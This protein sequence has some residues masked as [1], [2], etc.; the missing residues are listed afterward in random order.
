[1]VNYAR[2]ENCIIW[3]EDLIEILSASTSFI[4]GAKI[5][6][7]FKDYI[8]RGEIVILG[9]ADPA[10]FEKYMTKYSGF[11]SLFRQIRIEDVDDEKAYFIANSV[12]KKLEL[13]KKVQI[14][15]DVIDLIIEL[16]NRFE[17]YWENPGKSINL[18]KQVVRSKFTE[19]PTTTKI[20]QKDVVRI[21]SRQTGL[22]EDILSED[23][24]LN[25]EKVEEFFMK[26][27]MGQDKAVDAMVDLVSMIKAGM[28]DPKKPL[29]NFIFLGPT[30]VGKTFL[31][32]SL[33][34]YIFGNEERMI[35]LDMSEYSSYD[36][37][38][39]LLGIPGSTED[40]GILTSRIIE[41]PFSLILLDE[42]EKAHRSVFDLLL[43]VLG[44]GRLTSSS[45]QTVDFRS[46]IIIMTSNLGASTKEMK[47][48][49][50]GDNDFNTD[51]HYIEQ[52]EKF[53]RPEFI[54]RIDHIVPFN[55]LDKESI[56]KIAENELD[57]AITRYGILSRKVTL[58]VDDLILD[59]II[60]HGFSPVYGARPVKRA[61]E[62]IVV[63]PLSR[64]V[65]SQ[66]R[67]A[68]DLL[69]LNIEDGKVV[70]K[71][72]NLENPNIKIESADPFSRK[73]EGVN[74]QE[75]RMKTGEL[76]RRTDEIML[77]DKF[78]EI[79]RQ[80]KNL[81]KK[82]TKGFWDK[83]EDERSKISERIYD[84]DRLIKK[85]HKHNDDTHYLEDLTDVV[86]R[87]KDL[88]YLAHIARKYSHLESMISFTEI[89]FANSNEMNN[90]AI[91]EIKK[92]NQHR[93][94]KE[95]KDWFKLICIMYV[96]WLFRKKYSFDVLLLK[97]PTD[98]EEKSIGNEP[99]FRTFP[100]SSQ[101]D[102]EDK[103]SAARNPFI[104]LFQVNGPNI[105]DFLKGENGLHK[106][107]ALLPG[108]KEIKH[109]HRI[110][111]VSIYQAEAMVD[112]SKNKIS[113]AMDRRKKWNESWKD[114]FGCFVS[115][116]E[117]IVREFLFSNKKYKIID[118]G[119][120]LV[121]SQI[122]T[123]LT[124]MLDPFILTR[125]RKQMHSLE[126]ED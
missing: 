89:E 14:S 11:L 61:I 10:R 114:S 21:F 4:R 79:N 34:E 98:K 47:S 102:L 110:V 72:I 73:Y 85:I 82:T 28:N 83:S 117:E 64:F 113:K 122:E 5:A 80:L 75:L 36:A 97:L 105:Y 50:F 99:E 124:G 90:K 43:Q 76:R 60:K 87:Q 88:G 54:N 78:D 8:S 46:A 52:M 100:F 58:E 17:P 57:K 67:K 109:Q 6:K 116:T 40:K 51:F 49:G 77:S 55:F 29:G 13:Q 41:Q 24:P 120:G 70:I 44:E 108:E 32:R 115:G 18:L 48:V 126:E 26:R 125:I 38:Q 91:L 86:C 84:L 71:S 74:L 119:S 35:R 66:K 27:V 23:P 121:T 16:T 31:A 20:N 95:E 45:G 65:A 33:A 7:Y 3:F 104:F 1:M 107:S 123:I 62:K 112:F 37:V 53:F 19:E 103:I 22:P 56:R 106:L 69:K 94:G 25:L 111:E 59:E 15:T 30:G 63:S 9:E 101:K 96:K 81:M 2:Q 118:S 12:R 93:V 68:L 92:K 42:I 39:K